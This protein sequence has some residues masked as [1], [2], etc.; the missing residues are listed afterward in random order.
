VPSAANRESNAK[1]IPK[2]C[3][4][5]GRGVFF[6]GKDTNTADKADKA[7]KAD[8]TAVAM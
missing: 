1:P 8:G 3:L 7:L 6:D 5:N 2:Q 4:S